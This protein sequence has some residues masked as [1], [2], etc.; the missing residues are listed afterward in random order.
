MEDECD[1]RLI[2]NFKAVSGLS[3]ILLILAS[4]I[5]GA[6]LSYMWVVGYYENLNI[7]TPE[8]SDIT[9]TNATFLSQDTSFFNV[10][11]F[12]P[13]YSPSEAVITRI[14]TSTDDGLIHN[15]DTPDPPLPYTLPKATADFAGLQTFECNWNWA[16]YT[17]EEVG[18]IAFVADGSG[19]TL[20]AETPFV[21]LRITDVSFNSTI[22]ATH[23]N[24]TAQNYISPASSN[25]TVDITEISVTAEN[26]FKPNIAEINPALPWT[27]NPSES[28]N[29]MCTWDWTQYQNTSVTVA[30]YTSQG[31]MCRT[32]KKTPLPVNLEITDIL[33][34]VTN[35]TRFDV[36][37]KNDHVSPTYLNVTEISVIVKN[38][39]IREWTT[40][41]GTALNPPIPFTLGKNSTQTFVCPWNWA[42]HR[43]E[44][45]TV[46]V[47][48]LQGFMADYTQATPPPAS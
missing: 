1:M 4:A 34:D 31:Y 45:V 40:E 7:R 22:S 21:D 24:V 5:V 16:N 35:T 13:S 3:L 11:I 47:Y 36:T 32:T 38:Q 39:T 48:T 25:V 27:L 12:N 15:V 46:I 17:G 2:H 8:E 41:N 33:F 29:F 19:S 26:G 44:N 23:F 43:D 42:P 14:A 10:T 9:M 28:H 6:L 20:Q 30:L 18:I 37:V